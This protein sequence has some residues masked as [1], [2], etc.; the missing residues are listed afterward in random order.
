MPEDVAVTEFAATLSPEAQQQL[1]T[2]AAVVRSWQR[3][4]T[5]A[6]AA[7]SE[8]GDLIA[9]LQR[10]ITELEHQVHAKRLEATKL[11]SDSARN[12]DRADGYKS[13]LDT[14]N[15][16]RDS[17]SR[18]VLEAQEKMLEL[19]QNQGTRFKHTAII[20]TLQNSLTIAQE[21]VKHLAADNQRLEEGRQRSEDEC[22]KLQAMLDD[23]Q[24]NYNDCA[25]DL[26]G[27]RY[28]S[29]RAIRICNEEWYEKVHAMEREA[30]EKE[31]ALQTLL[32][33]LRETLR[34]ERYA[35]TAELSRQVTGN[36]MIEELRGKLADAEQ[37]CR[38]LKLERNRALEDIAVFE[39]NL[40]EQKA[41]LKT[42]KTTLTH[43]VQEKSECKDAW[44]QMKV[45]YEA[46][47]KERLRLEVQEQSD[48]ITIE[49]LKEEL[50]SNR[51]KTL[52]SSTTISALKA[53]LSRAMTK[54]LEDVNS[55]E[56]RLML[57]QEK[58]GEQVGQWKRQKQE[59]DIRD[60]ENREEIAR[61]NQELDVAKDKLE[62]AKSE[63]I[64]VNTELE[65]ERQC[66]VKTAETRK[67]LETKFI[68]LEE[69][70]TSLKKELE[71]ATKTSAEDQRNLLHATNRITEL[72]CTCS[73]QQEDLKELELELAQVRRSAVTPIEPVTMKP[74]SRR[75][76]RMAPRMQH[77]ANLPQPPSAPA[78]HEE[79]ASR[80]RVLAS[81]AMSGTIERQLDAAVIKLRTAEKQIAERDLAVKR[82]ETELEEK[83]R[84][85][86][87]LQDF[88]TRNKQLQDDLDVCRQNAIVITQ[89][90]E[91][92]NDR[93]A[94]LESEKSS[95]E[96]ELAVC[97]QA[98]G[99]GNSC[100]SSSPLLTPESQWRLPPPG[101]A[102]ELANQFAAKADGTVIQNELNMDKVNM[103]ALN[104]QI[105]SLQAEVHQ[106][107]VMLQELQEKL[108]EMKMAGE[109]LSAHLRAQISSAVQERDSLFKELE[110]VTRTRDEYETALSS[111]RD[112]M[113]I[114]LETASS[115]LK[116]A[117]DDAARLTKA[118][119]EAETK[120][121]QRN[122]A[123]TSLESELEQVTDIKNQYEI[124]LHNMHDDLAQCQE[125]RQD[126]ERALQELRAAYE[127]SSSQVAL[128]RDELE[129]CQSRW[130]R[131]LESAQQLREFS[132][133][134]LQELKTALEA[135]NY[136]NVCLNQELDAVRKKN[137]IS[138]ETL[139]KLSAISKGKDDELGIL[140]GRILT[141]EQELTGCKSD[142]E[143]LRS[144]SKEAAEAFS[145][146]AQKA[147][148]TTS[149]VAAVE[150]LTGQLE[151]SRGL[152]KS[153]NAQLQECKEQL[154]TAK[155][156]FFLSLQAEQDAA[157]KVQD[158]LR[159]QLRSFE[160]VQDHQSL[161]EAP[162]PSRAD[163]LQEQS[164]A[165]KA[166]F[167]ISPESTQASFTGMTPR[168]QVLKHEIMRI[169]PTK[170][171]SPRRETIRPP[172]SPRKFPSLESP[173]KDN[174]SSQ[175]KAAVTVALDRVSQADTS[176]SLHNQ[177]AHPAAPSS[178]DQVELAVDGMRATKGTQA[179]SP[180]SWRHSKHQQS[181]RM[182]Q[183]PDHQLQHQ[184]CS[185]PGTLRFSPPTGSALH[186]PTTPELYAIEKEL[187]HMAS[188]L[189]LRREELHQKMSPLKISN[190]EPTEISVKPG[191]PQ[192]P[193]APAG[194]LT[195]S[196]PSPSLLRARAPSVGAQGAIGTQQTEK[197]AR[198]LFNEQVA[199]R[200]PPSPT[201]ASVGSALSQ[202]C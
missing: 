200:L 199:S 18:Q 139:A 188:D 105:R 24:Q 46:T 176:N 175:S 201:G 15:K 148:K 45:A 91:A 53:E 104:G 73:Q 167:N 154:A 62:L 173:R 66:S 23:I 52:A 60:G 85:Q 137:S 134:N 70:I 150:E 7:P 178:C 145:E 93:L 51:R 40:N 156:S 59:A 10:R 14:A 147:A 34:K 143:N 90:F 83:S 108:S 170:K 122:D 54:F 42:L 35:H 44:V 1:Q 80:E 75:P 155:E 193:S 165:I 65:A 67:M 110:V 111:G 191:S 74:D 128:S 158:D 32:E 72:S 9:T 8:S 61:L 112:A 29:A 22:A 30:R 6:D 11:T 69:V 144:E 119:T 126:G 160:A 36:A 115:S 27:V 94:E 41:E 86:E 99:R 82:L 64:Q 2:C 92:T 132:E 153:K 76:Q 166:A 117:K 101:S 185:S 16:H 174:K 3:D 195:A 103:D 162:T 183:W 118:L 177:A 172:K 4:G 135:T 184:A 98:L 68:S 192:V 58:T 100:T 127:D 79:D 123:F 121:D 102:L 114:A 97:R 38:A 180:G 31:K 179:A 157:Q 196:V 182:Q 49:N 50:E 151:E 56:S 187:M 136:D 109:D 107:D 26:D 130:K 189:D 71:M 63:L 164:Q 33:E 81:P 146:Q 89:K 95:A 87:L 140:R 19:E 5:S 138:E 133:R 129:R 57:C 21:E 77:P 142:L 28:E 113:R 88:E 84:L 125:E 169:S 96:S 202:F 186:R 17:A 152:L 168:I 131:E 159:H 39:T 171:P 37:E 78:E 181:P 161:L 48:A 13:L 43:E 163:P 120:L 197:A 12:R 20:E 116:Q 25:M 190:V 55:V 198:K 141:M 194:A 106:R 149:L 47:A 124:A